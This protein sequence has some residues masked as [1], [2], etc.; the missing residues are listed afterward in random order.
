MTAPELP[1]EVTDITREQSRVGVLG[2]INEICYAALDNGDV[3]FVADA[4]KQALMNLE[5]YK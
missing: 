1:A 2:Q 3:A 4:L 5:S